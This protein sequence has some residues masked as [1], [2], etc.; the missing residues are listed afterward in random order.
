MK[1][2][3]RRF[4]FLISFAIFLLGGYIVVLYALGY[5]YDFNQAKF[6]KTGSFSLKTNIPAEVYLNNKLVGK[7]SFL[8]NG[9]SYT[10]LLPRAYT[11]TV[12]HAGNTIWK[13]KI[14]IQ[15]GVLED[16]PRIVLL[17]QKLE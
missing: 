9:F 11:I 15:E 10:M 13:K 7:T 17:P 12:K 3:T 2:S 16:F 5:E 4:L 14:S 6:L 1:R 8:S